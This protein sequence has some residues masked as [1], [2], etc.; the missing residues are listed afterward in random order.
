MS[1]GD[2]PP[3][4]AASRLGRVFA[5]KPLEGGESK[6]IARLSEQVEA[7]KDKLGEVVFIAC[8]IVVIVIDICVLPSSQTWA[9]PVIIAAFQLIF[10]FMMAR[11]C[12]VNDIRTLYAM[13][14]DGIDRYKGNRKPTD[15]ASP[16]Q[17]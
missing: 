13:L 2:E 3:D 8:C 6:E 17:R 4:K 12:R 14:L 15:P 7:L 11:V 16:E 5:D 1:I 10:L 9:A